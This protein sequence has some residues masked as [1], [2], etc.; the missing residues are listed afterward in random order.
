MN[1][2]EISLKTVNDL[3]LNPDK[4]PQRFFIA[5]YQRGYR[6]APLQGG[7]Y[8]VRLA[9]LLFRGIYGTGVGTGLPFCYLSWKIPGGIRD[10]HDIMQWYQR[11]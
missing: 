4:E 10:A 2:Q 6:W 8:G 9:F 5:A 11:C 1:N 7:I 3:R